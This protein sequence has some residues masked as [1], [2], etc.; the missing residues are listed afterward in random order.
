MAQQETYSEYL[1]L[2]VRFLV[3]II[4]LTISIGL[5]GQ[6]AMGKRNQRKDTHHV[7][8]SPF[9]ARMSWMARLGLA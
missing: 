4:A 2:S 9:Q 3:G 7:D 8:H 6:P 5:L 1:K